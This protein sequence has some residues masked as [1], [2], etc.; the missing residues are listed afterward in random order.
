VRTLSTPTSAVT[1]LGASAVA[2]HPAG[3]G[4]LGVG[5]PVGK[6]RGNGGGCVDQAHGDRGLPEC[7]SDGEVASD[8]GAKDFIDVG[9]SP[10]DPSDGNEL[11]CQGVRGGLRCGPVE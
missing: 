7:S 3:H 9:G 4:G 8:G 5:H 6:A 2:W 10:V 11:L 1:A